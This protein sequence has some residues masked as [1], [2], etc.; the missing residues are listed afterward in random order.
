MLGKYREDVDDRQL[1]GI[2]KAYAT[3]SANA[4]QDNEA[5]RFA[6]LS[7]AYSLLSIAGSLKAI[8]DEGK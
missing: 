5:H 6:E 1:T 3:M 8:V 7:I 4:S 2:A